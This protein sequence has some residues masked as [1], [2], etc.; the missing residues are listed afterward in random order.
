MA[1]EERKAELDCD[2]Q[3]KL[4]LLRIRVNGYT[5]NLPQMFV[6]H[7]GSNSIYSSIPLA[8][9][10]IWSSYKVRYGM[11]HCWITC[12]GVIISLEG[13]TQGAFCCTVHLMAVLDY[14]HSG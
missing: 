4:G 1:S 11:W 13:A 8:L 9:K 3:Q 14:I 5:S 10:F 2:V 6:A 7:R 12:L